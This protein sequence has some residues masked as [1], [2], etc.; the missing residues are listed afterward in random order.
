MRALVMVFSSPECT[1]SLWTLLSDLL[2][3]AH[4]YNNAQ[5]SHECIKLTWPQT[6]RGS[7]HF[8]HLGQSIYIYISLQRNTRQ[9][10][11][12][13]YKHWNHHQCTDI[14]IPSHI[15]K[16]LYCLGWNWIVGCSLT[17]GCVN[18][19]TRNAQCSWKVKKCT[20]RIDFSIY[21]TS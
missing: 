13:V 9:Y 5:A 18:W 12:A 3:S 17:H 10:V 16:N 19:A 14:W 2:N 15:W 7:S 20:P 4:S 8:I 6:L 21:N 1:K 11:Q